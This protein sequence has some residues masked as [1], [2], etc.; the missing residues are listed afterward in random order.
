[1][2]YAR[3]TEQFYKGLRQGYVFQSN[4]RA[5]PTSL[6][7]YM[8][9]K[10]DSNGGVLTFWP[11]KLMLR[12]AF[13]LKLILTL[14][15]TLFLLAV[16]GVALFFIFV[17]ISSP[18]SRADLFSVIFFP[19][20]LGLGATLLYLAKKVLAEL[21]IFLLPFFSRQRLGLIVCAD[22]ILVREDFL[23]FTI[24]PMAA[25]ERIVMRVLRDGLVAFIT[26]HCAEGLVYN[27]GSDLPAEPLQVSK[28]L[29]KIVSA[30]SIQL[31]KEQLET[32]SNTD[33]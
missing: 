4:M 17:A 19:F 23:K 21:L 25:L 27:F 26:F 31:H 13:F 5:L 7:N 3:N 32:S 11:D 8:K 9:G 30:Q 10:S 6:G 12:N 28:V 16:F 22:K 18:F 14:L 20:G 2:Q 24:L 33:A 15:Y 1:M 29:R